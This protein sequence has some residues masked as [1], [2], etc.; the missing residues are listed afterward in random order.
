MKVARDGNKEG[1]TE[2]RAAL[3]SRFRDALKLK[4]DKGQRK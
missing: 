1:T 3:R 2:Q 4:L